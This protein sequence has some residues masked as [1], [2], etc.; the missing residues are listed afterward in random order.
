MA[1]RSKKIEVS[2][3][4]GDIYGG[5]AHQTH[6]YNTCG[7]RLTSVDRRDPQV[8]AELAAYFKQGVQASNLDHVQAR[9]VIAINNN[10][11]ADF[12]KLLDLDFIYSGDYKVEKSKDGVFG[13]W[14]SVVTNTCNVRKNVEALF[15]ENT[16]YFTYLID[17]LIKK[18][19]DA[20][21]AAFKKSLKDTDLDANNLFSWNETIKQ[22]VLT[23]IARMES[24]GMYLKSRRDPIALVKGAE[25]ISLAAELREAIVIRDSTISADLDANADFENLKFKLNLMKALH[26]Q[27][28]LLESA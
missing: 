3:I 5:E 2:S 26:K 11:V 8:S 24:Y 28:E 10:D 23:Q 25:A 9:L 17:E 16:D 14:V 18:N 6:F 22:D 15:V 1:I 27:D 20:F 21:F 12:S 13:D 7:E 4:R 19:D